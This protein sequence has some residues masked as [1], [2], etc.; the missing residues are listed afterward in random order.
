MLFLKNS[1]DC[2]NLLRLMCENKLNAVYGYNIPNQCIE[3][4]NNELELISKEH[5]APLLISY[6]NAVNKI[7]LNNQT[8]IGFNHSNLYIYYLLG[9]NSFNPLDTEVMDGHIC[10]FEFAKKELS[11]DGMTWFYT[12]TDMRS[13]IISAIEAEENIDKICL[14]YSS[15]DDDSSI[16]YYII[17][18]SKLGDFENIP[19]LRLVREKQVEFIDY[20]ASLTN[21]SPKTICYYDKSIIDFITG[22]TD[23]K[24]GNNGIF[25]I[26]DEIYMKDII[27]TT[28]PTSFFQLSKAIGLHKGIGAWNYDIKNEFLNGASNMDT[29]F[30]TQDDVIEHFVKKFGNYEQAFK[31]FD[32]IRNTDSLPS[33]VQKDFSEIKETKRIKALRKRAYIVYIAKLACL[34]AYYKMNYP[35]AFYFAYFTFMA[36]PE[37]K[38]NLSEYN[39][40]RNSYSSCLGFRQDNITPYLETAAEMHRSGYK[41]NDIYSRY[42]DKIYRDLKSYANRN[43]G[44][45]L[46]L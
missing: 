22:R 32:E 24:F 31:L 44:D 12:T 4:V 1:D 14:D 15:F 2:D 27:E 30:A 19:V 43:F 25:Y 29:V 5:F 20:L 8:L 41:W 46:P 37:F 9:L 34:Q 16:L 10:S 7:A 6:V 26:E 28:K 45:M 42:N 21:I 35:E 40:I 17:P 36:P 3:R 38:G 23:C 39:A 18:N 13:K 11:S 33:T